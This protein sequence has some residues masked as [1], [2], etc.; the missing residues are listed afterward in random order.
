MNL[1]RYGL[2]I[3]VLLMG[4]ATAGCNQRT[5]DLYKVEV[6]RSCQDCDLRGV[7]LKNQSLG[8]KYRASVSSQP[9]STGPKG[10]GYAQPVDLT[11]ADLRE[12]NFNSANLTEVVLNDTQLN[13]ADLSKANLTDAQLVDAD[14]QGAN[15]RGA[16]LKGAN[17]QNANLTGADLREV[18]LSEVDLDGADLTD[19]LMDNETESSSQ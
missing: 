11:G 7:D 8:G 19:V 14:L 15:L 6:E 18:D 9:L 1:R 2:A 3:A 13:Q 12:A 17:L 4:L 10:L 5:Q 16:N